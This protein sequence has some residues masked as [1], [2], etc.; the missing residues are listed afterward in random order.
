M[1]SS[2]G[3]VQEF[4]CDDLSDVSNLPT[5]KGFSGSSTRPHPGSTAYVIE[6]GE[7]YI[8]T[9]TRAWVKRK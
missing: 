5:G 1:Q 8:L 7:T 2:E 6:T 9:N 4:V 3:R